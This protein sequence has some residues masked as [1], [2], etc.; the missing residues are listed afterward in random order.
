MKP[1]SRLLYAGSRASRV[2]N[3]ERDLSEGQ[4]KRFNFLRR[5]ESRKGRRSRGGGRGTQNYR[6]QCRSSK[7]RDGKWGT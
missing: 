1:S 5:T 4:R 2:E 7:L 3:G 6:E